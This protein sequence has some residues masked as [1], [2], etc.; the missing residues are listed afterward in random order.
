MMLTF[1]GSIAFLFLIVVI[2]IWLQIKNQQ[3]IEQLTATPSLDQKVVHLETHLMKTL[4][5]VQDL[6]K[7]MQTQQILLDQTIQKAQQ[8]EQ[9]NAELVTLLAKVVDSKR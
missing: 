7:K 6:A 2:L 1:W 9:Q 3:K 8:L 5:V 4:E